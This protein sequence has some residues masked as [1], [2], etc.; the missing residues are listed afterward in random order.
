MK[1]ILGIALLVLVACTQAPEVQTSPVLVTAQVVFDSCEREIG[2]SCDERCTCLKP[3]KCLN[4]ICSLT[5]LSDGKPC[6]Q[7]SQCSSGHCVSNLCGYIDEQTATY[8]CKYVCRE[9]YGY[10]E[11]CYTQCQHR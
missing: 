5:R 11:N 2:E 1:R 10:D 6:V 7:N 3:G 4:G 8:A 9:N